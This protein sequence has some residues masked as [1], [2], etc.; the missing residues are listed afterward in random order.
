MKKWIAILVAGLAVLGM[1]GQSAEAAAKPKTD[2]PHFYIGPFDVGDPYV[3]LA[4]T[5]VGLGTT[6]AYFAIEDYRK[7]HFGSSRKGLN[8]HKNSINGGA[9]ALTTVG[10]MALSPML[11]S[12][13][14][15]AIEGRELSHREALGMGADCIVPFL[16][17]LLWN[18]AYD[19]HPEWPGQ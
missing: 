11:A 1:A 18:A 3:F 2:R 15:Y 9:F 16:G 8:L 19:A 12:A 13:L 14:V 17:S 5:I 7:L 10:C 4:G 6:G